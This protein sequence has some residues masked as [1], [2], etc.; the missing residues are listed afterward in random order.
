MG[1]VRFLVLLMIL[2]ASVTVFLNRT[3]LNIAIVSMTGVDPEPRFH[4][5]GSREAAPTRYGCPVLPDHS[6]DHSTSHSTGNS[7]AEEESKH[8][9][10]DRPQRTYEWDQ[11]TQGWILGSFFYSYFIFMVPAG[12][13][14]ERFGGKWV[15]TLTLAGPAL[16][17]IVVP[18]ITDY[19]VWILIACRFVLGA[20]QAG[21][22]PSAYG[23]VAAWFPLKE[24]SLAFAVID[25]GAVL[26]AV[27][28]YLSAGPLIQLMGWEALFF[29]PGGV[30]VIMTVAW[31]TGVTS[32]PEDHACISVQEVQHIREEANDEGKSKQEKRKKSKRS[33]PWCA[34]LTCP[35]VMATALFK[36]AAMMSMSFIYLDL[37]KYLS[38]VIHEDISANG[39]LNALIYVISIGSMI[40]N[41]F[42]SEHVIQRRWLSRTATRKLYSLF[43][44]TSALLLLFD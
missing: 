22:Y 4:A 33:A 40:V 16:A 21:F 26:G 19:P 28:T 6:T 15:I 29:L 39:S 7:S 1:C 9:H 23:M 41:G 20:L 30:A 12:L 18:F 14:A 3:N 35:A 36:F 34:I 42:L 32:K 10:S 2:G 24:R 17:S 44:G 11:V 31:V 43:V 8:Q 37:P 38:E 13:L 27:V 25:V 5:N